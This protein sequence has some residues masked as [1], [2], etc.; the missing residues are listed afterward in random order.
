MTSDAVDFGQYL[1]RKQ[2]RSSRSSWWQCW[3][4]IGRMPTA[5]V[6]IKGMTLDAPEDPPMVKLAWML[7]YF[8]AVPLPD[9]E[10]YRLERGRLEVRDGESWVRSTATFNDLALLAHE[11]TRPEWQRI[12]GQSEPRQVVLS[13]DQ[14][15]TDWDPDAPWPR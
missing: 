14:W 5:I 15:T 9:G 11:L 6:R 13:L 7:S 10:T 1:R 12:A 8:G 4:P 2:T 3:S